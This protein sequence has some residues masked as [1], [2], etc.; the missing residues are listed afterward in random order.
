MAG[1]ICN[2]MR[3]RTPSSTFTFLITL[4]AIFFAAKYVFTTLFIRFSY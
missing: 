3:E 2:G 4:I 1:A